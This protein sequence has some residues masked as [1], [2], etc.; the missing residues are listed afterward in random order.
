VRQRRGPAV[1][2]HRFSFE[3]HNGA[4][5]PGLLVLHRCDNPPCVRPEHLF[6]GTGRDNM[7][8]MVGKGRNRQG[9]LLGAENPAAKLTE[10]D[11]VVILGSP[12]SNV[13]VAR[14]YGTTAS[15]V[16]LIRSRR[17]WGH[18]KAPRA[19]W[20]DGRKGR[21][22]ADQGKAGREGGKA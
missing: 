19:I 6:L 18:V 17:V 15:L 4:I 9:R 2:A 7:R 10:R 12:K 13:E 21:R 3:L 22:N 5:P 1:Y 16:G 8:D 14:L 11:V 20:R